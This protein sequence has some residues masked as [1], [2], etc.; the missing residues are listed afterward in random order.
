M[1]VRPP[2]KSPVSGHRLAFFPFFCNLIF[3][4]PVKYVI[5]VYAFTGTGPNF[6]YIKYG[7]QERPHE[8]GKRPYPYVKKLFKNST[9]EF[10]SSE[11]FWLQ[12]DTVS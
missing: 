3:C 5:H 2:E 8:S 11:Q 6:P 9:A 4:Q 12:L 10:Q 7:G 1:N